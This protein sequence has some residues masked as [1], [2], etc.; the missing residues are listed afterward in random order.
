MGAYLPWLRGQIR[1]II[2]RRVQSL[3]EAAAEAPVVV[4]ATGLAAGRLCGDPLVHPVRGHVVIVENPGLD[5]SVRDETGPTYVHPRSSDVVLG[6]TFDVGRGDTTPDPAEAAAIV[7]RCTALVPELR[8]AR[9]I[10]DRIGLRPARTGGARVERDRARVRA[11]R[12]GHDAVVGMRRRGGPPGAELS[13]GPGTGQ[14]Q[15]PGNRSVTSCSRKPL[16]SGSLND[17][18]EP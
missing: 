12:R 14:A 11:R 1:Q 16:P 18:N 17:A 9:I 6:G 13:G 7:E 3:D 15:R 2:C 5:E 4:N 8:G 10:G